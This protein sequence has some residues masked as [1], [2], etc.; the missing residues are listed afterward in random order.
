MSHRIRSL[1]VA[2]S[3]FFSCVVLAGAAH[4][5]TVAFLWSAKNGSPVAPTNSIAAVA[6]DT[7]TLDLVAIADLDGL[8]LI[9]QSLRFDTTDLDLTGGTTCPADPTNFADGICGLPAG[10][11]LLPRAGNAALPE[12]DDPAGEARIFAAFANPPVT[13]GQVDT[14]FVLSRVTFDVVN[15]GSSLIEP[16]LVEGVDGAVDG[17]GSNFFFQNQ[18]GAVITPEPGTATLV[19]LGLV[20][21]AEM[22]RRA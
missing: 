7:V 8:S 3:L 22:R 13:G 20:A 16:F 11:Q 15:T 2:S 9:S 21:L 18:V 6:G 1:A 4:A 17:S 14:S 19:G 12:L 5:S 10:G